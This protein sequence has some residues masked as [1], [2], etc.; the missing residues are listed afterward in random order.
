MNYLWK[1]FNLIILIF[2]III[3]LL[4][5]F[6]KHISFGWG[7][8]DLVGYAILYLTT[9]IHLIFTLIFRKKSNS[10]HAIL[11]L[12]FLIQTIIIVL[13]AT[14]WRGSEYPWNGNVFYESRVN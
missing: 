11:T 13:K 8:G 4:G 6:Y 5:T 10:F 3:S 12:I 2:L 1:R 14:I 7:L 9:I